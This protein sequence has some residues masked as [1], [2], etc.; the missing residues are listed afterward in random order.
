MD[1]SKNNWLERGLIRAGLLFFSYLTW[2]FAARL[3]VVTVIT[4]FLMFSGSKFQ[5]ISDVYAANEIAAM[6]F[7]SL[8]YI[9]LLTLLSPLTLVTRDEIISWNKLHRRFAPGVIYGSVLALGV[10]VAFLA[11]GLYR[12]FGFFIQS[13]EGILAVFNV[14]IRGLAIVCFVF[15]EEYLFRYKI[16]NQVRSKLSDIYA[17]IVVALLYCLIKAV[18]FDVGSRQ[19][20]TLFLVSLALAIRSIVDGDS[21]RGAGF[22]AAILVVFHVFLGLPVFG[23]EF[24]GIFLVKYQGATDVVADSGTAR[25]LTGGVG[26]PLSSFALQILLLFDVMQ[27]FFKHKKTLLNARNKWIK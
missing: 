4:Y 25:F 19:M 10:V 15:C 18:Q 22:W 17:I 16:L 14:A 23:N 27:G 12:Y 6:G 26:G 5:E 2:V 8:L 9:L 21:S 11:S 3:L 24:Q 13:D 7:A 1:V 20:I